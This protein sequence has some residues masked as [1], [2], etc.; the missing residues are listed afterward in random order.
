MKRRQPRI[1][2]VNYDGDMSG[3]GEGVF[4]EDDFRTYVPPAGLEL[5]IMSPHV[6]AWTR[7]LKGEIEEAWDTAL[8]QPQSASLTVALTGSGGLAALLDHLAPDHRRLL[9]LAGAER[10][11]LTPPAGVSLIERV[12]YASTPR[13]MRVIVRM[14]MAT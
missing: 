3:G 4:R 7:G 2:A 14:L 12:V 8:G 11:D 9:R 10:I 1:A 13:P 6:R 5:G